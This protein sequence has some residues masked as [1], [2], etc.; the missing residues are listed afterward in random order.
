MDWV[1]SLTGYYRLLEIA[2]GDDAMEVMFKRADALAGE[3]GSDGFIPDAMLPTLAR[4]PGQAKKIAERLVKTGLWVRVRGGYLIVDWVS[5]NSE[6]K[7]LQDKKKRDRDRKRVSRA[8]SLDVSTD[9]A[10]DSP[11]DGHGD[12]L[13]ESE[14]QTQ[15]ENAAAATREARDSHDGLQPAVEI[16]RSALD[17]RKLTVRWDRLT[18]AELDEIVNLVEVHGDAAL[19]KS[20][21]TSFQPNK[22][23]VY[24]KA[25]LGGWR[26]LRAPGDLRV[27]ADPC[28][29]PGHTGTAAYC[30]QCASEKNAVSEDTI[31]IH[32]KGLR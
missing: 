7:K 9:A 19:V 22:P 29:E 15:R 23:P 31:R 3:I 27:V 30:L 25:W 14:R 16:L 18:P 13:Y 32:Q 26:Q 11:A 4:R 12:S 20:A 24:A 2:T 6:L 8:A 17:A 28:A 5:I 10:A 1:K 21:M